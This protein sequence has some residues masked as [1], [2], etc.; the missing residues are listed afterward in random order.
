MNIPN[1]E[2]YKDDIRMYGIGCAK[3]WAKQGKYDLNNEEYKLECLRIK[4]ESLILKSR[5]TLTIDN[6]TV[7]DEINE[8]DRIITSAQWDYRN[9]AAVKRWRNKKYDE[10]QYKN[11]RVYSSSKFINYDNKQKGISMN[12]KVLYDSSKD[13]N[14]VIIFKCIVVL[15][16][17][18]IGMFLGAQFG[19]VI[20]S[21]IILGSVWTC[22]QVLKNT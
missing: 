22:V 15:I 5:D 4:R 1:N 11:T 7:I 8:I 19:G 18:F 20:G 16:F 10:K 21:I 2:L 9:T 17:L 13:S 12:G 6:Q 3:E 14:G